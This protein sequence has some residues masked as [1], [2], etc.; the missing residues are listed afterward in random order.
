MDLQML[1]IEQNLRTTAQTST[2]TYVNHPTCREAPSLR[3]VCLACHSDGLVALHGWACAMC[4]IQYTDMH[5]RE[6]CA[7]RRSTQQPGIAEWKMHQPPQTKEPHKHV[8]QQVQHP[9]A[10]A[11]LIG[12][13]YKL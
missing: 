5:F 10:Q 8:S 6:Q 3:T 12:L 13:H 7:T 1:R 9:K 11:A 2:R 4:F